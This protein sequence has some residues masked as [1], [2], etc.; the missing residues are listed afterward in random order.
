LSQARV[1]PSRRRA[2][3]LAVGWVLVVAVVALSLAPLP[4]IEPLDFRLSDKLQHLLAYA[5]LMA[6]F[7]GLI[8]RAT[9]LRAAVAL[10]ALGIAVELA[11]QWTGYRRADGWD[12]VADAAGIL[13][14]WIAARAFMPTVFTALAGERAG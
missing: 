8:A 1:I 2:W 5:A 6:W 11:Q 9:H 13:L 3:L 12:V 4:R 14:G 10:L 7:G